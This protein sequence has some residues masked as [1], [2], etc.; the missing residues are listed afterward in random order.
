LAYLVLSEHW[1]LKKAYRHIVK[2]R[3]N[4]SPNIGFVAELMK[5]EEDVHG[6][7]S[8]FAGTDWHRIDSTHPPSPDTQKEMGR[9]EK[10]W[11]R[12]SS[13]SSSRHQSLSN[14]GS[15]SSSSSKEQ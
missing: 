8:N 4:I 9:L 2:M 5:L 12:G 10:A 3:P 6:Q 1:T 11:K 14:S 7:V 15:S 13:M